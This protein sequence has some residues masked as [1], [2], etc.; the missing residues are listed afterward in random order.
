MKH[1]FQEIGGLIECSSISNVLKRR[2]CVV[3]IHPNSCICSG[4]WID[5][6]CG[7]QVLKPDG[8]SDRVCEGLRGSAVQ[9]MYDN[10]TVAKSIQPSDLGSL[11]ELASRRY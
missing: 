7:Q 10:Y 3:P 5:H 1:A 11:N 8:A 9:A 2:I 6:V 4:V